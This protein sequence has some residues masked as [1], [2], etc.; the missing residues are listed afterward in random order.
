MS[1]LA[2]AIVAAFEKGVS[3]AKIYLLL[4]SEYFDCQLA[5]DFLEILENRL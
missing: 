4:R 1:P 5:D 3:G 2:S